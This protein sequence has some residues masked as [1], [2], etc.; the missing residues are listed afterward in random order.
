M[1]HTLPQLPYA[2]NALEPFIC[3]EIVSGSLTLFDAADV[4]AV[5]AVD[6]EKRELAQKTPTN[7]NRLS[8]TPSTTRREWLSILYR[9]PANTPSSATLTPSTAQRRVSQKHNLPKT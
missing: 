7:G 1:A 4:C 2:Y 9:N 5:C 8:T 6:G 3:E